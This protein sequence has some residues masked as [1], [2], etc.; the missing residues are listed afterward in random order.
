MSSLLG[1]ITSWLGGSIV[2]AVKF[3]IGGVKIVVSFLG[4]Y[5][6][7]PILLLLISIALITAAV[8]AYYKGFFSKVK[9]EKNAE[10]VNEKAFFKE[11]DANEGKA[12]KIEQKLT[13]FEKEI[14]N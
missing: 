2:S 5:A 7:G 1:A 9:E 10:L 11:L 3:L 13:F 12:G 6:L 14:T 4:S 8:I